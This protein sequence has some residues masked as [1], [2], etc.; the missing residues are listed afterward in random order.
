ML[1]RRMLSGGDPR[2]VLFHVVDRF[3]QVAEGT[4]I[5]YREGLAQISSD[6]LALICLPTLALL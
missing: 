3:E 1:G 2:E 5:R 6:T 4:C